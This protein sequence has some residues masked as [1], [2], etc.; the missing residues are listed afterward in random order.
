V[1]TNTA[2]TSDLWKPNHT[3]Y[4]HFTAGSLFTIHEVRFTRHR[5]PITVHQS[6]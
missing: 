2:V 6:L 3:H 1:K 4:P 5:S